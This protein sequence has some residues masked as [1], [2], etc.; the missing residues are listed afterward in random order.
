MGSAREGCMTTATGGLGAMTPSEF[1]LFDGLCSLAS[2]RHGPGVTA[3]QVDDAGALAEELCS[4]EA[5]PERVELLARR[6]GIELE[7]LEAMT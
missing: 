2:G 7:E 5:D 3:H 4:E 6:L 1:E